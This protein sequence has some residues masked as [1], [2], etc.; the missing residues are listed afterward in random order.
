M[1]RPEPYKRGTG[2]RAPAW[3]VLQ[4]LVALVLGVSGLLTRLATLRHQR[5]RLSAFQVVSWS[6]ANCGSPGQFESAWCLAH[7]QYSPFWPRSGTRRA[8]REPSSSWC[9]SMLVVFTS[10]GHEEGTRHVLVAL[11]PGGHCH[12]A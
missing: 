9:R 10:P 4:V 3:T 11:V 1:G 8:R 5:Y 2:A 6:V 12:A 7:A